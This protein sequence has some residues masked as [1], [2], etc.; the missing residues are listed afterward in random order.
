MAPDNLFGLISF[1]SWSP[2][3][4][5]WLKKTFIIIIILQEF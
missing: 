2:K 5:N 4:T 3:I 1:Q